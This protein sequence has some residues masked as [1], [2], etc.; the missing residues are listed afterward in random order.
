[1]NPLGCVL[2][3]SKSHRNV[4]RHNQQ[5]LDAQPSHHPGVLRSCRPA[6]QQLTPLRQQRFM[7]TPGG[8][9]PADVAALVDAV[10]GVV[11]R[12]LQPVSLGGA[13]R[14]DDALELLSKMHSG[15][16]TRQDVPRGELHGL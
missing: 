1:M 2:R 8:V 5:E 13:L 14:A 3:H 10:S 6:Q 16:R 15:T 7:A 4:P 11:R 9:R 12:V